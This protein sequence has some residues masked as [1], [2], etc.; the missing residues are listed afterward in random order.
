MIW[1]VYAWLSLA[2]LADVSHILEGA[3]GRPNVRETWSP[4]KRV[5]VGFIGLIITVAMFWIISGLA[6]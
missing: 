5:T 1:I 4:E 2:L 3:R 6:A